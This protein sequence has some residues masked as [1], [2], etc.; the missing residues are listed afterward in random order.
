MV[1][2]GTVVLAVIL[3]FC[4]LSAQYM[5]RP[6]NL[7]Y[8]AQRADV[9]IQGRVISVSHEPLPGY[10]NIPTVKVMLEVENMVRGPAGKTYTIRELYV[11]LKSREGKQDYGIGQRL[12]LFLPSPSQ[13]GLSSPIG[14][15]QGRFL[16]AG[17]A[18]DGATIVNEY[19]NTGLFRNV[20]RDA[21]AA[22]KRLT[23]NQS[24]IAAVENGPV[25]LSEFVSLVGSLTSLPRIQ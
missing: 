3:S 24:R 25:S 9:I 14:M 21:N 8:L 2:L 23:A 16:I 20:E 5:V 22:G 15:G 18:G 12:L 1:R 11:G 4:P 17:S 7:A 13:Y 10:P 19:G 6:V